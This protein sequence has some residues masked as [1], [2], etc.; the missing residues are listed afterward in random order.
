MITLPPLLL[1]LSPR[2]RPLPMS[3]RLSM[4]SVEGEGEGGDV[5]LSPATCPLVSEVMTRR[6]GGEGYM[7]GG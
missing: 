3:E 4:S 6:R 5:P 2:G 1:L 7:G